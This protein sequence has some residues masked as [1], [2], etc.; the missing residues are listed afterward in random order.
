MDSWIAE[1]AST[2]TAR[3]YRRIQLW[4]TNAGT[5]PKR[6]MSYCSASS[7]GWLRPITKLTNATFRAYM[8]KVRMKIW[9]K[10]GVTPTNQKLR[11]PLRLSG[12]SGRKIKPS[13]GQLEP[14]QNASFFLTSPSGGSATMTTL[15]ASRKQKRLP[16]EFWFKRAQSTCGKSPKKSSAKMLA[17]EQWKVFT[18]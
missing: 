17:S 7:S 18:W 10:L 12:H 15:L 4:V 3:D 2:W 9:N 14:I 1:K 6:S 8:A 13:S 5:A 11:P 16:S